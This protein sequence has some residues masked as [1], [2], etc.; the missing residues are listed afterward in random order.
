MPIQTATNPKTGAR[1]AFVDDQ[2]KPI[3]Q[4]AT[5]PQGLKAY[6]ISG[7][8]LTDDGPSL[9]EVEVIAGEIPAARKPVDLS[10]PTPESMAAEEQ[11]KTDV[12]AAQEQDKAGRGFLEKYV[13]PIIEVPLAIGS[14]IVTAP[15][16]PFTKRNIGYQPV[17][18]TSQDILSEISKV[19]EYI[20]GSSMGFGPLPETW[21]LPRANTAVPG[22][23]KTAISKE[24]ALVK[25]AIVRPFKETADLK[26]ARQSSESWQNAAQIDAAKTARELGLS[27][28]PATSNPT[29]RNKLMGAVAGKDVL[30]TKLS[31]ANEPKWTAIAKDEMGIAKNEVLNDAAFEKA[32]DAQ[33][34]PYNAVRAL[35]VLQPD[36]TVMGKLDS[37]YVRAPAI[38]G[39]A[40][41]TTVNALLDEAKAKITQGRTGAQVI[42]DIRQLRRDANVIYKTQS[43]GGVSDPS[44]VAKADANMG[45]ANALESLI[46]A[47]VSDFKLL[48]ELKAARA[49]MAQIY[50]YQRATDPLTNKVDPLALAKM[51]TENKKLSGNAKRMAE[52]AANFPSIAFVGPETSNAKM[53]FSRGGLGGAA[54]YV[55]GAPFGMGPFTGVAGAGIGGV[56]SGAVAKYMGGPG[57]QAAYAVPKDFRLPLPK[58]APEI[59][60]VTNNLPVPYDFRN[61]ISEPAAN[62][63]FGKNDTNM[64]IF[65]PESQ[66]MGTRYTR[67][68]PQ[69]I[70][71]QALEAPSTESFMGGVQQ[72]RAYDYNL[73]KEFKTAAEAKLEAEAVKGRKPTGAGTLFEL[74]PITGKLRPV[75]PKTTPSSVMPSALESAVQKLSGQVIEDTTSKSFRVK[76]GKVDEQ[77]APIYRVV[78][79]KTGS[80][81]RYGETKAFDMTAE[82]RIAW[83]RTKV[84]LAAV[85]SSLSKLSDKA[86][87]EK[88]LDRN[89]VADEIIKA[90]QKAQAFDE[91]AKRAKTAQAVRE[92]EIKR[93]QLMDAL[94]S[95]ET[96]LGKPRP[97]SSGAQG[98]KTREAQR[99]NLAPSENRNN[100]GK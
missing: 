50:D 77:N 92:A 99:N 68:G 59:T 30:D 66:S 49:R 42:D 38:G 19:P 70:Y 29:A 79:K 26:A 27:L 82:E 24:A 58:A 16:L 36:A 15:A 34:K 55:A 67:K 2:W 84:E 53:I 39:E 10:V 18:R 100:L 1:L 20:T 63:T 8:W 61:A 5:N 40:N 72:R 46:D 54:G 43:K 23:L 12:R 71:T 81:F 28:N 25:P 91:I 83:D 3:E 97:V 94:E 96:S 89:W 33:S 31:R 75:E 44:L 9:P 14:S 93:D 56:S 57:Y 17:S 7:S 11:R 47:N 48:G 13:A 32:L 76:T 74:D 22:Q 73:E 21:V 41:A 98:P 65:G 86:L 35:P 51:L 95:L 60:P 62:F 85:D 78:N 69:P 45:V 90:R 88:M 6:K 52:V 87:A 64:L 4:S 80:T 37:L